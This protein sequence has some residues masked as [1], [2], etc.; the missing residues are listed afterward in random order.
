M[1]DHTEDQDPGADGALEH[2]PRDAA[3]EGQGADEQSGQDGERWIDWESIE[4]HYRA[5][6]LTL[7]ELG[8]RYGVTRQ[9]IAKR[10]ARWGWTRDQSE[11][12]AANTKAKVTEAIAKD[13]V[14]KPLS[15]DAEDR[16]REVADLYSEAAADVDIQ[17]RRDVARALSIQRGML[18]ELEALSD[19][20]FRERLE[21]LGEVMKEERETPN[22]AIIRDKVNDLYKYI[23]SLEGRIKSIKD[24]SSAHNVYIPLQRKQY[25]LE[26]AKAETPFE[27]LLLRLGEQAQRLDNANP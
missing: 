8:R 3:V 4:L 12:I 15:V 2:E 10:A 20:G 25:G 22:G 14:I 5:G 19:P 18:A 9:G 1:T 21:W 13:R 24:L 27:D 17:G 6:K 7:T 11:T 16:M 23:I 26:G